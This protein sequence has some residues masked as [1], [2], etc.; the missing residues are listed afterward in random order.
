MNPTPQEPDTAAILFASAQASTRFALSC[1]EPAPHGLR[2]RSSFVDPEG[3]PMH[4]HELGDLEGPGW[5]AN[6]L[7]GA[8]LLYRWGSFLAGARLAVRQKATLLVD[9]FLEDGFIQPDGFIWPY[10]DLAQSRFCLNYAHNHTWLCPGSLSL[11]GIQMIEVAGLFEKDPHR[12]MNP[13]TRTIMRLHP[14]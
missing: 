8:L 5:A 12:K 10:W 4:W 9:H 3:R 2:A 11:I 1:L 7:G 6:A 14:T 13:I